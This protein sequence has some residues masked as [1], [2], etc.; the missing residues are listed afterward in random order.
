MKENVVL[1]RFNYGMIS[2]LALA[3]QDIGKLQ[4]GAAIQTNIIGRNLGAGRFRP[5]FGYITPTYNNSA[6]Y[7]IPFVFAI[8]DTAVVEITN[9]LMRVLVDEEVVTRPS[10]TTAI[11]NGTFASDLTGWTQDDD[12]GTSSYWSGGFMVLQGTRYNLA[13]R[14]QEVT[15]SG[16]NIG[17]EHGIR[18]TITRGPVIIKIG[19][20]SGGQDYLPETE[21]RDGV[22]SFTITPT[23]NFWIEFANRAEEADALIDSVSI[24]SAG[25]MTLALPYGTA[26]LQYIR[27]TQSG[28]IIYV[29]CDGCPI[30]KIMRFSTNG[31]GVADYL[32]KDGPFLLPNTTG[33]RMTPSALTGQITLTSSKPYF[34]EEMEGGLFQITSVGQNVSANLSGADQYTD[35][36]KVT[37]I[38]GNRAF[39]VTR[40]G[41]WSGTLYLQRSVGEVG[42]WVDAGSTY[43]SN[44]TTTENDGQD[45]S[46]IYYRVG[47]KSATY[48]SGTATVSLSY[49]GG[50]ITGTC[51]VLD[52]TNS[53]NVIA[54]VLKP[55]GG[56]TATE[57]WS[58]GAWSEYRGYP[59][60]IALFEG[61]MWLA[62]KDNIWGSLS[63]SYESFDDQVEGDAGLI[64]RNLG[65]G[66][67]DRINWLLALDRL[68]IGTQTSERNARSSSL[69]E[70]LTPDNFNIKT[71]STRG[72]SPVQAEVVDI[73]GFFTRNNRLFKLSY[74]SERAAVDYASLDMTIIVPEVGESG[75]KQIEVQRYPDT[76]IHCLRND[77]KVA[78]FVFD[79]AEDVQCWQIIETD[80]VIED[81]YV[82]PAEENATEDRV[83]YV[84]QRT[85]N[86]VT[87]DTTR[88]GRWSRS[89][90][91]AASIKWP[92]VS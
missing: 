90:L 2:K 54:S 56:T 17:V 22:Y 20:T 60:A 55:L 9:Q 84:V 70:P 45:N 63:D 7:N 37:G 18:V 58:E 16:G 35:P 29:G 47:F 80:G 51:R 81:M 31:W 62:G 39:T 50:G 36:I 71:P 10:V 69:D 38:S 4:L 74:E 5:G 6:C 75:F 14:R 87:K 68:A 13:R 85:I 83:Y 89:A 1:N 8:D 46:I 25:E 33:V 49:A 73:N 53:T 34:T 65:E 21:L 27:H 30:K 88:S 43:T 42:A 12:A 77:G 44:A 66:P 41:T 3:R 40:T 28:D 67:I 26:D 82:L 91:A 92:I 19:S 79:E 24:E 32:P 72:S 52:Y 48:T 15:V 11:T 76:R 64:S 23:G 86:G 59:S 61:R 57:L 78:L